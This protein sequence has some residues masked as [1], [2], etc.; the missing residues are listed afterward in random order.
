MILDQTTGTT[1]AGL[2]QADKHRGDCRAQ[3]SAIPK[4]K[5]RPVSQAFPRIYL[6][7]QKSGEIPHTRGRPKADSHRDGRLEKCLCAFFLQKT[8]K[9]HGARPT[10]Y[11]EEGATI[12]NFLFA[13]LA[14]EFG[15]D[16]EGKSC[17][18]ISQKMQSSAKIP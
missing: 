18:K 17:R 5:P 7:R 13:F 11:R 12:K 15:K 10:R 6:L 4:E 3:L 9:V 14:A 16:P 1:P 8:P 2:S